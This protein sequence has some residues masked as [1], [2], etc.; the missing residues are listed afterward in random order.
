MSAQSFLLYGA[1]GY[2]GELI[3]RHAALYQL[4]PILAGRKESAIA[5]M[6]ERLGL[7]YRVFDLD[8]TDALRKALSEVPLVIHAAGPF[9][10][11]ATQMVEACLATGT[12]YLDINGD[13]SVFESLKLYHERAISAGIMIM[14]GVGFDVVPTDCTAFLLKKLLPDAKY[15]KL[16]F[17]TLGGGLSHGTAATMIDKLGDGGNMRKNGKI[18]K[19]PLG[20]KSISIDFGRKCLFLMSIP[21]GDI[22]TAYTS[23]GIPDI[24]TYTGISKKVYRILKLQRSF[25]WLLRTS[26]IKKLLRKKIDAGAPGP[27]DEQRKKAECFVW[28]EAGNSKGAKISVKMQC[29]EGYTVTLHSSLLIAKKIIEGKFVTGYQTPSLVFGEDLILELPDVKRE[30][31]RADFKK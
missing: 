7:E 20:H 4:K 23:T 31:I 26:F 3:A 28:G 16:G 13:I 25:N 1:N 9:R 14:P 27:T 22:S 2:T 5:P 30:I 6:A 10:Y 17:A 24:E 18:I 19:V 12:H 11:T 15:L 8:N 21:W 29:P